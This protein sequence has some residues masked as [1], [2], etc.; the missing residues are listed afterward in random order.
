LLA[1][2]AHQI[3]RIARRAVLVQARSGRPTSPC[4]RRKQQ[5]LEEN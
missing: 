1:E 4:P 2:R 5:D 3:N